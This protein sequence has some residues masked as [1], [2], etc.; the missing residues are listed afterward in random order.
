MYYSTPVFHYI[1]EFTQTHVH[2]VS[3]TIQPSHPQLSPSLPALTLKHQGLFQWVGCSHQVAKVSGGPSAWASILPKHIQGW[4]PLVWSDLLAVQR[5]LKMDDSPYKL[6][7]RLMGYELT[8]TSHDS[9]VFLYCIYF[10]L[11]KCFYFNFALFVSEF[12]VDSSGM[13]PFSI[14]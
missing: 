4:L 6:G 3:D 13:V 12:W 7:G 11:S 9:S 10:L 8:P 5:T 1:L 14:R 2:W